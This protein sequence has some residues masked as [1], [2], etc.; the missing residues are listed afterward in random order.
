MI[1]RTSRLIL[2]SLAITSPAAAD[3]L[4]KPPAF[5]ICSGCHVSKQGQ[6]PTIGPNLFG[7]SLR[8]SGEY[9]G[10][11]YSA[12][13]KSAAVVWNRDTLS[14]FVSNPKK[15]IPGTKMAYSGQMDPQKLK[16]VVDYLLSLK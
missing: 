1:D 6:T 8:K 4:P 11:S 15:T 16:E 13:M 2:L 7:V 5:A 14:A 10:Y 3:P 12:A 9:P